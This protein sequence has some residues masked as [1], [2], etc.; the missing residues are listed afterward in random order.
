MIDD[1]VLITGL[2]KFKHQQTLKC[3]R[4]KYILVKNNLIFNY[5]PQ[6][7]VVNYRDLI[8]FF[9]KTVIIHQILEWKDKILFIVHCQRKNTIKYNTS[10][11][12]YLQ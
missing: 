8:I 9:L 10:G 6:P 4:N 11:Q 5:T 2:L 12:G 1:W 3:I 7:Y